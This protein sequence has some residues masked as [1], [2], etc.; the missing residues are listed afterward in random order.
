ML[1][2][3]KILCLLLLIT[4][5]EV[6]SAQTLKIISWNVHKFEDSQIYGDLEELTSKIDMIF[7]Q[8]AMNTRTAE[9]HLVD[10]PLKRWDFFESFK[11]NGTATGVLTGHSFTPLLNA[12]IESPGTEPFL[13]TPKVSGCTLVQIGKHQVLLINTHALNFNF[14]EDFHDQVKQIGKYI[15]LFKGPVIWA[16]DFN[17]WADSR[18]VDLKNITRKLGLQHVNPKEDP[19]FLSLDHFFIRGFDVKKIQVLNQYETSD[20]FPLYLEISFK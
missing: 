15:S 19:R 2:F 13:D 3:K 20:H 6:S 17:T 11:W 5:S 9:K 4:F 1:R 8:E 14:G 7:I 18:F 16:G 10:K 12:R